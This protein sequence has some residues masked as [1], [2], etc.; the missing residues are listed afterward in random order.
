M[1]ATIKLNDAQRKALAAVTSECRRQASFG[2]PAQCVG[3]PKGVRTD[4]LESLRRVGLL[5]R[6][7]SPFG[8][9]ACRYS[10]SLASAAQTEAK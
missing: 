7:Y 2:N 4:T 8:G 1:N 10:W 5:E 3:S 6:E 9:K